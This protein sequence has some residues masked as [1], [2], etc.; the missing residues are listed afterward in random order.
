MP[1]SRQQSF[2]EIYG[3]PENF[4]EIEV[5]VNVKLLVLFNADM[6]RRS[7]TQE[8]MAWDDLCTQ[9]MKFYVE[10]ISQLSSCDIPQSEDDIRTLN[11]S[12][13]YLSANLQESR[14]LLF[15]AKFSRTGLVTM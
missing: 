10:P 13:I 11:I 12:E 1:D 2:E 7:K 14:Y 5:R 15:L 3:P 4:L 9:T 8:R 6:S